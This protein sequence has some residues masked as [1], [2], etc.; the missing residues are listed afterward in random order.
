M[1]RHFPM[2]LANLLT[3]LLKP[4]GLAIPDVTGMY[5]VLAYTPIMIVRSKII[6][7]KSAKVWSVSEPVLVLTCFQ[8]LDH[9]HVVVYKSPVH[10]IGHGFCCDTVV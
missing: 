7:I 8:I 5:L 3:K 6:I 9:L 1:H 4:I 2:H 10:R